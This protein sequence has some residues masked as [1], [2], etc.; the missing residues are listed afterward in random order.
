MSASTNSVIY[1]ATA[2]SAIIATIVTIAA[3]TLLPL[4]LLL[5]PLTD[6]RIQSTRSGHGLTIQMY[7]TCNH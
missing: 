2:V 5:P 7:R 4:S 6:V 1:T 3:V